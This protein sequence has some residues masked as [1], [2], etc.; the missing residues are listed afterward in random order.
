MQT[1]CQVLTPREPRVGPSGKAQA[2]RVATAW[3]GDAGGAA[4]EVD[5]GRCW[6]GGPGGWATPFG[7][8][9]PR[10]GETA[11]EQALRAV[12]CTGLQWPPGGLPGGGLWVLIPGPSTDL[13]T[14][15]LHKAGL[16]EQILEHLDTFPRNRDLCINGLILLWALLVDGEGPGAGVPLSTPPPHHPRASTSWP[17]DTSGHTLTWEGHF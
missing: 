9:L 13:A 14:D 5:Y 8:Q 6:S 4:K 11:P 2:C 12:G 10:W 16:L 1:G 15:E 3:D 17:S 7:C